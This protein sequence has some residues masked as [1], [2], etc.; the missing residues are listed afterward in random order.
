MTK[1][2]QNV[3]QL[4]WWMVTTFV[5]LAILGTCL[6]INMRIIEDK[7]VSD[8]AALMVTVPTAALATFFILR[9][10]DWGVKIWEAFK[11]E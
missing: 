9:Q 6:G 5:L 1:R 2:K 4:V 8:G 11:Y 10:W 3:T 7:T